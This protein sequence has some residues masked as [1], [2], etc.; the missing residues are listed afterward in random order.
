MLLRKA[1][2]GSLL[3]AS[4]GSA[5]AFANPAAKSMRYAVMSAKQTVTSIKKA[6]EPK[7][8]QFNG[9]DEFILDVLIPEIE[10]RLFQAEDAFFEASV[11]PADDFS[12]RRYFRRGCLATARAAL[13]LGTAYVKSVDAIVFEPYSIEFEDT[14]NDIEVARI[15]AGC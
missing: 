2:A 4:L 14:K 1:I 9:N 10:D 15:D 3:L 12:A 6:C 7:E 13:K 8:P 11:L 5:S